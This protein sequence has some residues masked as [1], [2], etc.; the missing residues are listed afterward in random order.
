[1]RLED[2]ILLGHRQAG[3]E[4][5]DLGVIGVMFA[6]GFLCLADLALARQKNE[7]V[8]GPVP[9]QLVG[10]SQKGGMQVAI[11]GFRG[12]FGVFDWPVTHLDRIA[13]A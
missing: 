5:Q 4:R 10:G 8:A 1:M 13:A 9:G 3:K 7:D 11:S 6:Q 12:R 2:A